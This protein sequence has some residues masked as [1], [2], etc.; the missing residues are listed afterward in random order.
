MGAM[1]NKL[2]FG[3]YFKNA[4][5]N[6][7]LLVLAICPACFTV[8]ACLSTSAFIRYMMVSVEHT[9]AYM[10]GPKSKQELFLLDS[11]LVYWYIIYV[12]CVFSGLLVKCPASSCV[13]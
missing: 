4:D 13:I 3:N 1:V 10:R 12:Y 5:I 11:V 8:L 7:I 9:P 2:I 6:K